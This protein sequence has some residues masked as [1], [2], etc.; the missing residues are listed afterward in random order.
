[1]NLLTKCP[2]HHQVRAHITHC[3]LWPIL[4]LRHNQTFS[5]ALESMYRCHIFILLSWN[6]HRLRPK[7]SEQC[8]ISLWWRSVCI[9]LEGRTIKISLSIHW[10]KQASKTQGPFEAW[11]CTSVAHAFLWKH[12]GNHETCWLFEKLEATRE[13]YINIQNLLWLITDPLFKLTDALA[14]LNV[15]DTLL[16]NR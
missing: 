14:S 11:L 12:G 15:I 4:L 9:T 13:N 3:P 8:T 5:S 6:N 10:Q 7:K 1:M 2:W 16:N